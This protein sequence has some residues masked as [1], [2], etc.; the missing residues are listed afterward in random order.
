MSLPRPPLLLITDRQQA[1]GPLIS[2]LEAA[3]AAGCRWA[4]LREKDLAP[5]LQVTLAR[6]LSPL[7]R[8]YGARLTLHGDPALARAAGLDGAHLPAGADVAAARR[9]LGPQALVGISVHRAEEAGRLDPGLLDYVIAG[10]AF[11]TLS[12]PGYGP[13][14]GP[15]GLAA[16]A[17]ATPLPVVAVGGI[18]ADNAGDLIAAGAAG[19]AVMGGIMRAVHPGKETRCLLAALAP[20][21]APSRTG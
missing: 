17:R 2:V 8:R 9:L 6:R 18:E 4:S 13:V 5:H 15:T 16:I 21:G 11:A 1:K 12:K 7:A 3:F 20:V 14:L 19:L 10:P